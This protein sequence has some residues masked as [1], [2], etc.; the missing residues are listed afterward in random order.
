[1]IL[2]FL[3]SRF[4]THAG[5]Q[6]G[7]SEDGSTFHPTEA[8]IYDLS[9]MNT[10]QNDPNFSKPSLYN[11]LMTFSLISKLEPSEFRRWRNFRGNFRRA[12]ENETAR[13][14]ADLI[15]P[16]ETKKSN[17]FNFGFEFNRFR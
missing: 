12:T 9:V 14:H 17:S 5:L 8:S 7:E 13:Q 16:T 4:L 2:Q 10:R 1:M 3:F 11:V 15:K 6:D